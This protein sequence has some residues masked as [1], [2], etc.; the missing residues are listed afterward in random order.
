MD[1]MLVLSRPGGSPPVPFLLLLVPLAFLGTTWLTNHLMGIDAMYRDWP[2]D[3]EDPVEWNLGWQQVE[4]G[5]FR[6]HCP[7]SIRFGRRCLHL[8]QPFPF[9]PLFW[10][11]P[12]SVPWGEVRLEKEPRDSWWAFLSAA[13]FRLGPGGRMIRLRGKTAKALMA[14]VSEVQK[15]KVHGGEP[16]V[17]RP[18]V[19]GPGAIRPK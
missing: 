19:V 3:R 10:K 4:F 17:L 16:P 11:G 14:R 8:K 5:A 1:L 18:P 12:A 15:P 13:E 9:Q 6:G 2:A 7:M